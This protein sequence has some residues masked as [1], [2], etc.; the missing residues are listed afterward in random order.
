MS[1]AVIVFAFGEMVATQIDLYLQK[2]LSPEIEN[3]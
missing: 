3:N 1:S 2:N